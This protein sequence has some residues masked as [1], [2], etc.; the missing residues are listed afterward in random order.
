ME[1]VNDS[2]LIKNP[3]YYGN[4]LKSLNYLD[5]SYTLQYFNNN[6]NAYPTKGFSGSLS[7]YQRGFLIKNQISLKLQLQQ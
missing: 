5:F 4:N 7:I 1:S 2:V 3:D 6:Y